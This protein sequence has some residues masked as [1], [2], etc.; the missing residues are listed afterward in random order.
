MQLRGLAN[1]VDGPIHVESTWPA[2]V[3]KW[4]V[5]APPVMALQATSVLE[6]ALLVS[7]LMPASIPL[8]LNL[9]RCWCSQLGL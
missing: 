6:Q 4:G 9:R 1:E 3:P 2:R 7:E 5:N 8:A